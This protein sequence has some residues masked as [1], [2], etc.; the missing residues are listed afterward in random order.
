LFSFTKVGVK[1]QGSGF[2]QLGECSMTTSFL[3]GAGSHGPPRHITFGFN[4]V[5]RSRRENA[6]S[7]GVVGRSENFCQKV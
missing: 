6:F 1:N 2:P 5:R 7:P 3:Y 4:Q